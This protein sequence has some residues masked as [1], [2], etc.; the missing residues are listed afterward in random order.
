VNKKELTQIFKTSFK[1]W[2]AHNAPISAAALTFFIIL[3]LP[4]LLLIAVTIFSQ[5][6]GQTIAQ[7]QII[8][9][10]TSLAG[11]AVAQLFQTLLE[12]S[13]SPFTSLWVGI[14][15]VAFSVGGAIGAFAVLRDSMDIIWDV[16]APKKRKLT[17][18][19]K[20]KIGPFIIV[21]ILGL[22]VIA[23]TT[24]ANPLFSAIMFYSIN[25]TL[26]AI[27][28][29]IVQIGLSFVVST[30]LFA[31][32]YKMI[33]Q[34]KVHWQDVGL[35][36]VT[37]GIAFTA[38]NYILGSYIQI[39]TV[40]TIFGAAGALMIILLWIYILNQIVLFGAEISKTYAVILEPH[41]NEHLPERAQKIVELLEKVEEIVEEETK[42]QIEEIEEKK[43]NVGI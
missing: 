7:Q 24:I 35:A 38:V 42:G 14:T 1:Q 2:R 41:D 10:I 39:F 17:E 19:I 22:I 8:Q 16:K 37:T 40:T 26:T 25:E 12:S 5:F 29:A 36:A 23:W 31:F 20:E 3:P 32:I 4:S 33:P 28:L 21:S 11:P 6:Y 15:V 18:T 27:A 43:S 30:M 34:A 9:Q 13:S